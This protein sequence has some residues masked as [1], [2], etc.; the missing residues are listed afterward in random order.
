M[1]TASAAPA[2][3]VCDLTALGVIQSSYVNKE[4]VI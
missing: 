4:L 2:L 1:A 3:S